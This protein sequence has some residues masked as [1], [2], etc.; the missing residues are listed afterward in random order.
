[1]VKRLG[2]NKIK[3]LPRIFVLCVIAIISACNK[4]KVE[5][6]IGKY[7]DNNEVISINTID[8]AA[9]D[10][11][12]I[13]RDMKYADSVRLS[14][15]DFTAAKRM[16]WRTARAS[17]MI[18]YP[19]GFTSSFTKLIS[20]YSTIKQYDS[21]LLC[22][23]YIM[24]YARRL[25][26][27]LCYPELLHMLMSWNYYEQG[28]Y[29]IAL[30][31]SYTALNEMGNHPVSSSAYANVFLF[32]KTL[33]AIWYNLGNENIA[34]P[35]F[36]KAGEVAMK[37]KDPDML[38]SWMNI[39]ASFHFRNRKYDSARLLYDK[40]LAYKHAKNE[41]LL[42]AN[43]NLGT[44]YT[45]ETA[46]D[47]PAKGIVYYKEALRLCRQIYGPNSSRE[48]AYLLGLGVAY[49]TK[50]VK[51][52]NL[53]DLK[54]AENIFKTIYEHDGKHVLEGN[55]PLFYSNFAKMY[56]H[57][58]KLRK[59]YEL[60]DEALAIRD[61]LYDME[62]YA[63]K[64][65]LDVQYRIAEKD[66]ELAAQKL[67]IAKQQL[68]TIGIGSLAVVFILVL[69]IMLR[70]KKHKEEIS[71]L[72]AMMAGEENERKR[73][74]RDLHDGI[75][76]RLSA[77]KLKFNILKNQDL[78]ME[79]SNDFKEA[80]YQLEQSIDELRS[81]SHNLYPD[82]LEQE[83]LENATRIFCEKVGRLAHLDIDFQMIG[84]L[85][86]LDKKFQLDI[87]RIIQELVQ[88]I[89]KHSGATHALVQITAKEDWLGITIDDN[90]R[91]LPNEQGKTATGIKGTG[92]EQIRKRVYA[93]NGN[94]DVESDQG[95]S[96]YIEFNLKHLN[97][98]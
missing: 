77:I 14:G 58:G 36:K 40:I 5:K 81:T 19:I 4:K 33:G 68:W 75:L 50:G 82:V 53:H 61:S 6:G 59:A 35:Y 41:E 51:E 34:L 65:K 24:P 72:K 57:I 91:G 80:L 63:M 42:D 73:L 21:A 27:E 89:I 20:I 30:Q 69:F 48:I 88:N 98:A 23:N 86:V 56:A 90:G 8:E 62:Q 85:P 3:R 87:Y 95:T 55:L 92:L 15:Q 32:Y 49:S 76:S 74:A 17:R 93:M 37:T 16:F 26:K 67:R 46:F 13:E 28:Q 96:F 38:T 29:D 22:Y 12:S 1:M 11:V 54:T 9:I 70:R 60:Q 10:V 94:F 64:G 78:H 97:Y 43:Y 79:G 7:L 44:L 25:P 31:F 84:A 83:G 45:K 2:T 47:Q 52:N 39:S 66:K 71:R 18:D